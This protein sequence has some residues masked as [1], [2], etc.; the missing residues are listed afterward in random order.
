MATA[1]FDRVWKLL[2]K[3][4]KGKVTTYGEIARALKKQGAARAVGNACNANPFASSVP[5][6]RV[7]GANGLLGGFAL[8]KKAKIRLLEKEDILVKNG[9]IVDFKVKFWRF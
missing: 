7:V 9:R 2:S 1:F 5:C 8:G 3:I 6:H 4:P